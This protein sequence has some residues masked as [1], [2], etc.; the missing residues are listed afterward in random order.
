MGDPI[1]HSYSLLNQHKRFIKLSMKDNFISK[2]MNLI[3]HS[4]FGPNY[5]PLFSKNHW[6]EQWYLTYKMCL[7]NFKNYQNIYFVCFEKLCESEE[8]W[9]NIL[10]FLEVRK[11]YNYK[12]IF[13]IKKRYKKVNSNFWKKSIDLYNKL[14]LIY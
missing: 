8:Y 1:Q 6:I 13:P 7:K 14:N 3:G 9:L 12:F 5:R 2:Y 4:E 11:S 10:K